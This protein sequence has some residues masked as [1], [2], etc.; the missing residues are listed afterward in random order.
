LEEAVRDPH[1]VERGLFDGELNVGETSL[2][3]LPVPVAPGFRLHA[4]RSRRA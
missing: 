2:P 4:K 1:F 3:A